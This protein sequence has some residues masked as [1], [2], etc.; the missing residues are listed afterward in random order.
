[1]RIALIALVVL[2]GLGAGVADETAASPQLSKTPSSQDQEPTRAPGPFSKVGA[3]RARSG[4]RAVWTGTEMIIW[5]GA[6]GPPFTTH[7]RD[8]GRYNPLTNT[9]QPMNVDGA[10][11]ARAGESAVWTGS[12]MIIWGGTSYAEVRLGQTNDGARYDPVLDQWTPVSM[13]NAPSPRSGHHAVWTGL[14]M[15]VWGGSNSDGVFLADGGLYDP[16]TDSWRPMAVEGTPSSYFRFQAVWT[17][18]ELIVWGGYNSPGEESPGG[19][20]DP[21]RNEWNPISTADAPLGLTGHTMVWTGSEAI[22]W[23]GSS[24]SPQQSGA[25][26]D[27]MLD[28]WTPMSL[29]N[30]PRGRYGHNAVWTGAEMIVWWGYSGYPNNNQRDGGRYDP[31]SDTWQQFAVI[32]W[33]AGH[34]VVWT[35]REI[36]IW[37]GVDPTV[38]RQAPR[39]IEDGQIWTWPSAAFS[40]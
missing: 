23:G 25:R 3:P 22:V 27:P 39:Y 19:R 32:G 20:Y 9:W 34:S 13:E 40:E 16:H 1:V 17:G 12:E 6:N 18:T 35:G 26:Y 37:G 21:Q 10:P 11:S 24:G 36:I 31:V 14:E 8:G 7:F 5:G 33:R 29:E 4:H 15:L 28:R 38:P 30:A 2:L